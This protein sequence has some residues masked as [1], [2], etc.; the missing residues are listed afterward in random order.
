MSI[1]FH[2]ENENSP[3]SCEI[4]ELLCANKNSKNKIR[5]ST[6]ITEIRQKTKNKFP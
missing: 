1:L 6:D 4:I 3:V 5:K 2:R